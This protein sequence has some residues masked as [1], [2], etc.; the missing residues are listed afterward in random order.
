MS[1]G[2][3][4]YL[5]TFDPD[6]DILRFWYQMWHCEARTK[7]NESTENTKNS[8]RNSINRLERFL[9]AQKDSQSYDCHW[10]DID[11]D[12]VAYDDIIPPREVTPELAEEFLVELQQEYGADTQQNTY[13]HLTQAYEWCAEKVE[14]VEINPF[15]KVEEKVK[16]TSNDWIL[17]TPKGRNPYIIPLED[18]RKVV[19]SWN[20]PMWLSIQLLFAKYTRRVGGI[21]NLDFENIHIAHPGCDWTV[22]SDLRQWPDHISFRADKRES[23]PGRNT[24]NKTKTNAVYPIDAELKD[25]L[26]WYLTIRPQPESPTD[27]LFITQTKHERLAG[28]NIYMNFAQRAKELGYWYGANDDDNLNPH[29]WRHWATSHYQSQFGGNDSDGYTA[30]TKYIRGDSKEDIIAIYDNYT[31][32]KRD[33]ILDAMPTFLEP[34]VED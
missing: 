33:T 30:L 8:V 24:G 20:H 3:G 15:A 17:D 34:Y 16:G 26:L 23:D 31:E 11:I 10:S 22:H 21:S 28:N 13:G 27:P 18:A 7:D 12:T 32:E 29:Y 5:E 4:D 25:A 2:D 6:G 19:R 1:A 9:A 14:S